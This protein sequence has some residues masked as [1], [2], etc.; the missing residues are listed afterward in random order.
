M[1]TLFIQNRKS[2]NLCIGLGF[3]IL[4]GI[5]N[6]VFRQYRNITIL[7]HG[8]ALNAFA[9]LV[10][11]SL[12]DQCKLWKFA[13]GFGIATGINGFII[14]AK[15][16][17]WSLMVFGEHWW[18]YTTIA[19]YLIFIPLNIVLLKSLFKV[20]TRSA[21]LMGTLLGIINAHASIM[22]IPIAIS[23]RPPL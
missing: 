8:S 4:V 15:S 10:G 11:Y 21:V 22:G 7:I 13:I 5:L 12:L 18:F 19:P 3:V 20:D 23:A 17:T 1:Q 6:I 2:W 16:W 14:Y 9:F